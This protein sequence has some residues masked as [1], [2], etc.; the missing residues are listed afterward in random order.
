M[1][2][3]IQAVSGTKLPLWVKLTASGMGIIS[4]GYGMSNFLRGSAMSDVIIPVFVGAVM[5][6]ASGYE[7]SLHINSE[8]VWRQTSFWGQ[9]KMEHVDWN[10]IA[11]ARVILNKGKNIYVLMHGLSPVWPLTF[12]RDQTDEV[13][14]ALIEYM[15]EEDIKIEK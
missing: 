10:V 5:V 15:R 3:D 14:D 1:K 13:L 11:D 6:Y 7:R 2:G 8:G 4:T 12:K 9:R